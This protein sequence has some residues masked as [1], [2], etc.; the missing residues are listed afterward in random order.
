MLCIPLASASREQYCSHCLKLELVSQRDAPAASVRG[1]E[2]LSRSAPPLG[3]TASM[4]KEIV[5]ASHNIDTLL[6]RLPQSFGT[7][8]EELE[9]IDSLQ[10]ERAEIYREVQSSWEAAQQTLAEVQGWHG[11]IADDVLQ[12]LEHR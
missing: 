2:A 9:R 8:E 3:D 7:Q 11:A 6:Q 4:A 1:E 10:K 12:G 5:E